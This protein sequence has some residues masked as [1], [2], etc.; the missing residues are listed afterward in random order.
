M[1]LLLLIY[2]DMTIETGYSFWTHT[3]REGN[4]NGQSDVEVEIVI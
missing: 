1:K 2:C 3:Q 4:K